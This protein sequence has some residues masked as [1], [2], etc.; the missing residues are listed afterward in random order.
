[1]HKTISSSRNQHVTEAL[2]LRK[3]RGR[4]TSNRIIVDGAREIMRA[5]NAGVEF[6]EVFFCAELC[7][8]EECGLAM[9]ALS[10]TPAT[11]LHVTEEVFHR[12]A[13]GQ[14]AEGIVGIA[15]T[16]SRI[17]E[18]ILL[19][20]NPLVLVLERVEKP[21]NLGAVVRSADGAGVHAV[22][23]AEPQTDLFN[24]NAIRASLGTIFTLCVRSATNE[25]TLAWL[26]EHQFNILVSL[27]DG[28]QNYTDLDLTGPTAF[29][30]GNEATGLSPFW[31][32]LD[33]TPVQLPM[34]GA[35]DSLNVSAT[36]AVLAYEALRQ[37][38][39]QVG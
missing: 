29:V 16:P 32:D 26:R 3:R 30:L 28:Q 37:R 24:P 36:A 18:D 34:R 27:V 13:Y 25:T 12:I 19:P 20:P 11:V 23:L 9:S 8:T 38:A 17:L 1:V 22:I 31:I 39:A 6:I 15:V 10:S 35:A 33:A 21:G 7:T 2:R 14:R 5:V 4:T